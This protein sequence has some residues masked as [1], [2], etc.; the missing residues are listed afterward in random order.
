MSITSRRVRVAAGLLAAP[1]ALLALPSM[2][3]ATYPHPAPSAPVYEIT[4]T[5]LTPTQWFTPPVVAVHSP[6]ADV[7]SR[8]APASFGVK[9]IAENGNIDPLVQSLTG[10]PGVFSVGVGV[11]SSGPPPLAPGA[12]TKLTLGGAGNDDRLSLV[13]MLICTNDGFAGIDS[14]NMPNKV[15]RSRTG[16]ARDFDAGTEINSE[17]LADIVPPCQGLNGVADD[18]G[19]PGTGASNPALAE[20]GVIRAHRGVKEIADLTWEAHGWDTR[21]PVLKITVTRV[22]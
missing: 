20:S 11:S 14:I 2:A 22:A 13:A 16:Y 18:N 6:H 8:G 9:E 19:A 4:L 17:D 5:N 10:A 7:Y 21:S 15:G 1:A 3:S 12:S